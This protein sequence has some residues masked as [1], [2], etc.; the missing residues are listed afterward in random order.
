M[1]Q[2]GDLARA[3]RMLHIALKMAQDL[4]NQEAVTHIFCLMANLALER[5]F[6]GQVGALAGPSYC[7]CWSSS[8]PAALTT[9][10][11]TATTSSA[12]G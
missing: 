8:T 7:F 9:I 11:T 4:A 1:S 5:G 2:E 12:P 3:D 6:M 10:P